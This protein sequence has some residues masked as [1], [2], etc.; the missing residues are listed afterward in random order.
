MYL[1][2]AVLKKLTIVIAIIVLLIVGIL[3]CFTE[4]AV[5]TLLYVGVWFGCLAV[6]LLETS[7]VYR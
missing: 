3:Y 2:K 4:L 7:E 6:M 1:R 5:P